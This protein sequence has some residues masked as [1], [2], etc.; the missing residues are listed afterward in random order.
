M[1]KLPDNSARQFQ[2]RW[3]KDMVPTIETLIANPGQKHHKTLSSVLRNDITLLRERIYAEN[4]EVFKGVVDRF[5]ILELS[6]CRRR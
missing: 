2:A 5:Q 4:Q 3:L 1:N 6:S